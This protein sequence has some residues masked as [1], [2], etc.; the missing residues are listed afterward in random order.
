VLNFEAFE[1]TKIYRK[2]AQVETMARSPDGS[3]IMHLVHQTP[4]LDSPSYSGVRFE[5]IPITGAS[6]SSPTL[7]SDFPGPVSW[8]QLVWLS[9]HEIFF[10]AGATPRRRTPQSQCIGSPRRVKPG[11]GHDTRTV[12]LI[13]LWMFVLSMELS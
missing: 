6:S 4:E 3:Q 10:L 1:P 9:S 8:A 7:I 12:R 5:V 13:A 11:H 2:D